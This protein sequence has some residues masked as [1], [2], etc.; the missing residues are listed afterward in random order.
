M[1]LS[2]DADGKYDTVKITEL[3]RLWDVAY[4]TAQGVGDAQFSIEQKATAAKARQL[5]MLAADSAATAPERELAAVKA[6]PLLDVFRPAS[7][8]ILV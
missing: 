2:D 1:H 6:E 8:R 3:A 4:N 5:L 7:N